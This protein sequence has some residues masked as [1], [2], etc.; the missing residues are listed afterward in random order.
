VTGVDAGQGVS[1]TLL[2]SPVLVGRDDLLDLSARRIEEAAGSEGRLLL[3]AGEAGIGKSR[4]LGSIGRRAERVGFRTA[5][6][7]AFPG[8]DETSGGLLLDLAG[9][10]R[11]SD[12]AAAQH[13]GTSIT[14][15]LREATADGG[16][17]HRRRRL[18]VQDLADTLAD[19]DV[20]HPLLVVLEDLHWADELSLEVLGHLAPKL[21]HRPVL[22]VGAYRS[23]ELYA[24]TPLRALRGRLV[25][26]RTAE[27]VVLPRLTVEQ[28]AVMIGAVQG[29]P[30]PAAV[31]AA[32]HAR[33]DGIPLYVEELLAAVRGTG[34]LGDVGEL[35]V[36]DSL[37]DVLLLRA[38]GLDP[39]DRDIADAAAVIG[40]TFDFDLLAAVTGAEP[41]AM[42]RA[43]R[44]AQDAFLVQPGATR[45]TFD[46]R[47]ALIRDALY[48]QIPVPRRRA[49]HERVA[50]VAE[51]RG[52]AAG[53]V[54]DQFEQAQLA[55]P[56]HRHALSA[57]AAAAGLSA[58][59]EALALYRRALRNLPPD[60]T[61]HEHAML[62][63]AL[64]NEASAVD[65]NTA[66]AEAYA[67]AHELWTSAGAAIAAAALVPSMVATAHLLGESLDS[68]TRR[69][70]TAMASIDGLAGS[71]PVLA[72]LLSALSA[73][74]MLDRRLDESIEYGLR[75]A[76]LSE[77]QHDVQ[78]RLDTDATLGSVLLFAGRDSEG[79]TM[80]EGA[81][82]RA[83]EAQRE[84]VAARAYRM[85]GSC[86][87][88]LVDYDRAD[89]WLPE[90]I[91]YAETVQLWNH[92]S[93][94]TAHHA[95]VRWATGD[96]EVAESLARHALADGRGGVTTRI[97]AEYVLGF[98][99]LGRGDLAGAQELLE[100]ARAEGE[101]MDELQR[102]SPPLW[103]L[104]EVAL[105]RG[106][107][108]TAVALTDRGYLSSA[109]VSDAAYLFPFL[110]TG[111]RARLTAGRADDAADWVDRVTT[112]LAARDIPGTRAAAD[113]AR[114][115]LALHEGDHVAATELLT[116]AR[117]TWAVRRRFWE[118]TWSG[119]DLARAASAAGRRG[120]AAPLLRAALEAAETAGSAPLV[121]AAQDLRRGVRAGD[122]KPWHPLTEREYTVATLVASG[123]TNREIADRL[124]VS[125][126][127]VSAHVEHILAKLGAGRRAEIATWATKV[128]G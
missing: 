112:A 75:S 106:D 98:L 110:V 50:T 78:T 40:R 26:Q 44:A 90:G 74:Y 121:A 52:Y 32:I 77:H 115:L 126:K 49:L 39:A 16:D 101:A 66:A 120:A 2:A 104:A 1:P 13:A 67:G 9:D 27:E 31:V 24:E 60:I 20:G 84:A 17:P 100:V 70:H 22:V 34:T 108:D 119:I 54:S 19:V 7:S 117:D 10:L 58:H 116:R 46:F 48:D 64:A 103:G 96:W 72:R 61:P 6:A 21:G 89:R 123:M 30:A 53:F 95:H 47:H 18:L 59:R 28:T 114:G 124:V 42:D 71:E 3:F 15:R 118:G 4:L 51:G 63:A 8:D 25:S 122:E 62:L 81:V 83:V 29:T 111:T 41:A 87:S 82:G 37:T 80:L 57:A 76:D 73:A 105:L 94:L 23:D 55:G 92:H 68:R 93:Y 99:A 102:F 65:D 128:D 86:A 43:L 35:R 36:P 45:D 125:P 12:V 85:I 38:A 5:R 11:R 109:R 113:H 127:T 14:D 69:V 79:W 88:V 56:A 33:S 97:T 91:G 107:H